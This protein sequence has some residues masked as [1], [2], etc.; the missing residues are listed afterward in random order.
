MGGRGA[1]LNRDEKGFF[2]EK[3]YRTVGH[4]DVSIDGSERKVK[5]L[6]SDKQHNLPTYS[7]S[8]NAIYAEV[9]HNGVV[10]RIRRYDENCKAVWDYDFHKTNS[11]NSK[12]IHKHEVDFDRTEGRTR[13]GHLSIKP[14]DVERFGDAIH[15]LGEKVQN[16]P[17]FHITK[18]K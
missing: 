6:A 18:E 14:E 10:K 5:V 1:H 12:E 15:L 2:K 4:F 3:R 13:S 9:D 8:P 17:L 16:N 11:Q 7:N